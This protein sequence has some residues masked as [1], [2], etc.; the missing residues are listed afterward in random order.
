M[1]TNYVQPGHVMTFTVP[2]SGVTSGSGYLIGGLFVVATSTVAYASGATFEGMLDGVWT[3]PKTT[4]EGALVEGQA[5][6]WDVTNAK[7]SIDSTVGHIP[8]GT[9]ATA[10]LTG[11]TTAIVRLTGASLAGRVVNVRKRFTIAQVNA[12]ATLVPALAGIAYRM[13]SCNAIAIGGAAGA[14]TTV[15][16]IG[17]LSAST[18]KLVAYA[19]ASLTQSTVLKDGGAGAAV[20]ADGASY[21]KNDAGAAITVGKTG[22]DITTA[23]HIDFNLTYALE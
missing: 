10:A 7:I 21:T 12:G 6:F 22:A 14:V 20:L 3:L 11:D 17:T 18:R 23:T 16:V 9:I 4:G 8:I 1:A 19:Q 13:V 2:A 15:D 5:A